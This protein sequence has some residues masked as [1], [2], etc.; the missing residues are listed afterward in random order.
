[1]SFLEPLF[2]LGLLAAAIPLVIHLINRRKATRQPF[3]AMQLLL[4]SN[5]RESSHIKVRHWVLLALRMLVVAA[6]A[7]ALAKPYFLS[8]DGTTASERLPAAV[9]LV[10]DDSASMQY[11]DWWARA[12]SAFDQQMKKL[13]PWDEVA[14]LT[15]S[16]VTAAGGGALSTR[17]TSD[18]AGI[19]KTFR[20]LRP[21]DVS[22]DLSQA[23]V[24]A[25][26]LLAV[27]QL[28]AK[29]IVVISD[30][31]TGGF[32]QHPTPDQ[33]IP[34]DVHEISVRRAARPTGADAAA[35]PPEAPDNLSI[36][37]V[38]YAREYGIST[39]E[40]TPGAG[41]PAGADTAA[42]GSN[43][44]IWKITATIRNTSAKPQ[45]DVELRLNVDGTDLAGGVVNLDAH[46]TA[47][48]EFRQ[49]F[50]SGGLRNAYVELVDADKFAPDNRFYFNINLRERIH[51]LLVNGEPRSLAYDDEMFFLVRA[52]NPGGN[53]QSTIIP[54]MIS[55]T[56]LGERELGEFDVVVLSNVARVAPKSAGKLEKFVQNGGGLFITMGAQVDADSWNQTMAGLLPKPLR[57]IKRLAERGD[58]DAP[59]KITQ[60]GN[61][62][63]DHPIFRVF[64]LAGGATLQTAQVYS[65]MLLEPSMP[66]GVRQILSYKDNAPAMV[67]RAVGKGRT[68]VFTSTVDLDWSDLALQT[69]YLPLMR[70]T[71]QYLARRATSAERA[72]PTAGKRMTLD[73]SGLVQ[74]RA[75]VRGPD[76]LRLV[77]E[78]VD[79][80]VNFVP[81]RLG[82]Y[83]VWADRDASDTADAA[84][85][86]TQNRL[87][88][89]AFA[90]N[91]DPQE[92]DLSPL[93][94]DALQPWT[95]PALV[96]GDAATAAA[97]ARMGQDERRVNIWPPILF[98]ITM[99]LLLESLVGTRRSVLAKLWRTATFQ[100]EPDL[101]V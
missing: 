43:L 49:N 31:A 53:T 55:P 50:D 76:E 16:Q 45:Q 36:V 91:L 54:E 13:R 92:S 81:E 28:P 80:Q 58:P 1:M 12:Q 56:A 22:T 33:V 61:R 95:N 47:S 35:K 79:G 9:V 86:A 87:D 32:P 19:R 30:F 41:A 84:E 97:R 27:S 85:D 8:A 99:L 7:M 74:E 57:G 18:H 70:R 78:P 98:G 10:V 38:D 64:D 62:L 101:E 14:L 82:F 39:A 67:E 11:A 25:S 59:V 88:A 96:D 24:S 42:R 20:K 46:A 6:L 90:V 72:Q 94:M 63:R 71:M 26:H 60:I 34:Y 68:L 48:Y 37:A 89:L 69:A 77:L 100:K 2:L 73:V 75:I 29:S 51:V 5:R 4:A 21:G 40:L 44:N 65:Y 3:P 17:L 15:T 52:L 83:Q 23:L 93:P 66:A